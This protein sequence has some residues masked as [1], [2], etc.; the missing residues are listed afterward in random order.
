[1]ATADN[2]QPEDDPTATPASTGDQGN[3]QGTVDPDPEPEVDPS[4]EGAEEP[5]EAASEDTDDDG[6]NGA[7]KDPAK[8]RAE[9]AKYRK[10]AQDAEAE[11]DEL[12]D[13]LDGL[14]RAEVEHLITGR[15]GQPSDLWLVHDVADFMGDDGLD[16]DR[17]TEAVDTLLAE[18]PNWAPRHPAAVLQRRPQPSMGAPLKDST[19]WLDALTNR[20]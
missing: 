6:D 16:A 9:A 17:I 8:L 4:P 7:S 15:L 14:R 20:D 13:E 1:M 12:R 3:P 19:T 11:R 18:R 2:P 10:R 5:S